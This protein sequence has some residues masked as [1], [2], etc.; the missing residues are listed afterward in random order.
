V[1]RNGIILMAIIGIVALM[2]YAG[3]RL[4]HKSAQA[5]GSAPPEESVLKAGGMA[6]DFE[7]KTLDGKAVKLSSFRGKAVLL[8]FWATWCGPC[9]IETPWIVDLSKRYQS[10]G[11]E[12][13]GVS[14]DDASNGDD[15]AKFV[16]EMDIN[17]TIVQGTE[18]VGDAYGGV[19]VLPVTYYIDRN[20]KIVSTVIGIKSQSDMEDDIKKALAAP[21]QTA[22]AATP[23]GE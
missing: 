18:A 14:M 8:N 21:T 17:Y 22:S 5:A 6:P 1:K 13:V 16:K 9:K 7:L 23:A 15:I 12:V 2:I 11:L 3:A 4:S 20:G 10:Q 19:G